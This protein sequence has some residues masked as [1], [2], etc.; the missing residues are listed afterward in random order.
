MALHA[1]LAIVYES[2]LKMPLY[3]EVLKRSGL[4]VIFYQ[5]PYFNYV[6]FRSYELGLKDSLN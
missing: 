4:S 2:V 5:E 1:S 3:Y 6:R